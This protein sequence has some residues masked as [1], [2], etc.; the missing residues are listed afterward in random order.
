[1]PYIPRHVVCVCVCMCVSEQ[2]GK[3]SCSTGGG[4]EIEWPYIHKDM[5]G[6]C[7]C[8][9][10]RVAKGKTILFHRGG[11]GAGSPSS[12]ARTHS[13]KTTK[14]QGWGE[15]KQRDILFHGG[16]GGRGEYTM[17]SITYRNIE[18][19]TGYHGGGGFC[20]GATKNK[21]HG[22]HAGAPVPVPDPT[23]RK[24]PSSMNKL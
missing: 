16:G 15:G 12:L 19:I 6:G 18:Y 13:W 2:K 14:P 5:V 7:M 3:P 1:M 23:I 9:C 11:W 20:R 4:W 8:V 21:R 10:V 17:T 22:T 24:C